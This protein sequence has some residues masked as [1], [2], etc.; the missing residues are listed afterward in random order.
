MA[1]APAQLQRRLPPFF[2]PSEIPRSAG[3]MVLAGLL[4][5][6]DPSD[7]TR[8][9]QSSGSV[10]SIQSTSGT[11]L[12]AQTGSNRPT[13]DGTVINGKPGITLA[14]ASSQYLKDD[15]SDA[16]PQ[17][18]NNG[19]Y[20]LY[21]VIK[22][23]SIVSK[24]FLALKKNSPNNYVGHGF[25]ASGR[26]IVARGAAGVTNNIATGAAVSAALHLV[27][28][29]YDGATVNGWVDGTLNINAVS[30]GSSVG[31]IDALAYGTGWY[32][33]APSQP[34]DGSLGRMLLYAG[35]HS[36]GVRQA[37]E[38]WLRGYYGF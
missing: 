18:S 15:T 35:A 28:I 29:T 7:S 27:S 1:R 6:I 23:S 13:Y 14:S 3:D 37:I 33:S 25:D 11:D 10:D 20:S 31:S 21:M 19:A 12:Y 30:A 17:A 38:V 22:P 5:Y 26:L 16:A 24:Q 32:S 36:T 9:A 4:A 8:L 34:M 2:P